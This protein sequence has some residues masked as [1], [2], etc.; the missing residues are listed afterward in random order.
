MHLPHYA[1]SLLGVATFLILQASASLKTQLTNDASNFHQ[2]SSSPSS[3][4]YQRASRGDLQPVA[5]N[6]QFR[7][8][9][10]YNKHKLIDSTKKD[11][12]YKRDYA[13]TL[14][15]LR[16]AILSYQRDLAA[17]PSSSIALSQFEQKSPMPP[18]SPPVYAYPA[19]A[20]PPP[21]PP[22]P[23]P[24][25]PIVAQPV[26]AP[27]LLNPE[28]SPVPDPLTAATTTVELSNGVV[29]VIPVSADLEEDDVFDPE[30]DPDDVGPPPF[31]NGKPIDREE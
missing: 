5:Y 18:A 6:Q 7:K 16:A 3:N 10:F 31:V 12:Y 24:Q 13:T 25:A 30:E 27:P 23:A 22:P 20:S 17:S 8:R 9:L 28:T 26:P 15:L 19:V 21:P 1:L 4:S 29:E 2:I 14:K 11:R